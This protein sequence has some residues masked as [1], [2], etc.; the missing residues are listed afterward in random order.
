M[1][2]VRSSESSVM[3]SQFVHRIL[4]VVLLLAIAAHAQ[5]KRTTLRRGLSRISYEMQLEGTI[6]NGTLLMNVEEPEQAATLTLGKTNLQSLRLLSGRTPIS[7]ASDSNGNLIPLVSFD[8]DSISGSYRIKGET[9]GQVTTF[10]LR[11]PPAEVAS[12]RLVTAAGIRVSSSDGL[13]V[14][15]RQTESQATWMIYP[16]NPRRLRMSCTDSDAMPGE[17]RSNL[18]ASATVDISTGDSGVV[19]DISESGGFP[20]GEQTFEISAD[21]RDRKSVV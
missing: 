5:E 2:V 15:A 19:W 21:C 11:L 1:T 20:E 13:V 14:S 16:R 6:L 10:D 12:V 4:A 7:L 17:L 8:T 3:T 18:E 9:T